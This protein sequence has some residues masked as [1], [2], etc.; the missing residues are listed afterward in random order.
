MSALA[1]EQA[2]QAGFSANKEPQR[3]KRTVTFVKKSP[4]AKATNRKPSGS[5]FRFERRGKEAGKKS[6]KGGSAACLFA[7]E[8][9]QGSGRMTYFC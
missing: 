2:S 4:R 1:S 9:E 5:G 7:K 6:Q 8:E 3:L